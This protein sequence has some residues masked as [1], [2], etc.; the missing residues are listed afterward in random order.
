MRSQDETVHRKKKQGIK[1]IFSPKL[2]LRGAFTWTFQ[3][4]EWN[5]KSGWNSTQ[6]KKQGAKLVFSLVLRGVS[7]PVLNLSYLHPNYCSYSVRLNQALS[8]YDPANIL[9]WYPVS[10]NYT[11]FWSLCNYMQIEDETGIRGSN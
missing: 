6:E 2:V 5:E 9:N 8:E 7:L 1:L 10:W 4:W 11:Q 3:D